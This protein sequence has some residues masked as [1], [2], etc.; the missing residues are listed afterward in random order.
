VVKRPVSGFDTPPLHRLDPP[1]GPC[2]L[3]PG[4]RVCGI[5]GEILHRCVSR[6]GLTLV[7]FSRTLDARPNFV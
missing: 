4:R 5:S 3:S 2:A 6:P 1:P 7:L